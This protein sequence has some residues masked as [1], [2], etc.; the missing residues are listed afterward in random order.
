MNDTYEL[1]DENGN[2][3]ANIHLKMAKWIYENTPGQFK[4]VKLESGETKN[5]YVIADNFKF[6]DIEKVGM[7]IMLWK[8]DNIR[9]KTIKLEN[10]VKTRVKP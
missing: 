10:A 1:R 7:E 3:K 4:E 8:G 6:G 9:I 5:I 2:L